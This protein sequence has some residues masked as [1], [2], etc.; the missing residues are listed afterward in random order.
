MII[1]GGGPPK[2]KV[3][4]YNSYSALPK[5]DSSFWDPNVFSA[6]SGF[7]CRQILYLNPCIIVNNWCPL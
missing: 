1:Y 2:P 6:T 5:K 7:I 3:Q 4:H